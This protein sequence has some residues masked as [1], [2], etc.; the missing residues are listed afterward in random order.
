[1]RHRCW[2][3]FPL[4]AAT[5]VSSFVQLQHSQQHRI[6]KANQEDKN[7]DLETIKIGE[8][9]FWVQQKQLAQDLADSSSK[10]LKHEQM[11]KFEKRRLALVGETAYISVFLF[12][13]LWMVAD[14]LYTSVS[15]ALGAATGIAYAYGLGKSV[16]TLGSS[17]D[18]VTQIQ[19]SGLGE[20][21]FAFLI[22]LFVVLGKFRGSTGIQEIPAIAGF[23]TYQLASLRQGLREIND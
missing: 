4:L 20:A 8:Q 22:L 14:S 15:Y 10:S 19:R 23:F 1:M 7:Y 6:L 2:A 17:P 9:D 11:E 3:V 5:S 12:A 21:R 18:E 16:E 13:G